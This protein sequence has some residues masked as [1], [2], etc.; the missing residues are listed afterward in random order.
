MTT[1]IDTSPSASLTIDDT[2]TADTITVSNGPAENGYQTTKVT[3]ANNTSA[4][5]FANQTAVVID[6]G[7]G[8]D[9]V[10]LNNPN[11]AAGLQSLTIQNLGGTG[12]ITGSNPSANGPDITVG[13][14]ILSAGGDIGTNSRALRTQVRTLSALAGSTS[15]GNINISN[16]VAASTTLNIESLQATEATGN[17]IDLTNNGSIDVYGGFIAANGTINLTTTGTASDLN[18]GS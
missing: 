6:G 12:A 10:V 17:F 16:G 7:N 1:T 3:D 15:S 4:T 11:P 18:I 13:T 14:L 9:N 5:I 2:T 8:G